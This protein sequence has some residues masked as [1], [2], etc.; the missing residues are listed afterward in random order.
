METEK[1]HKD[2]IRRHLSGESITH[3]CN[4]LHVSRKWFYKWWHRYQS[5]NEYWFQDNSKAPKTKPNKLEETMEQLILSIRDELEHTQ[6]AQLGASAI[7]WQIQKLGYSPPPYWTIK[8]VLKRNGR[9]KSKSG[10]LIVVEEK[11]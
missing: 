9:I 11:K 7:P 8:R 5:G 3:I 10:I 2:E 6:Y 4:E 1:L